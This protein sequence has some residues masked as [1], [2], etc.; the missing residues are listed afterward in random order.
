MNPPLE[1]E[2]TKPQSTTTS[3]SPE[4]RPQGPVVLDEINTKL[5]KIQTSLDSLA[6]TSATTG[7]DVQLL[8]SAV[9]KSLEEFQK[10][11]QQYKLNI[12]DLG[13]MV[14]YIADLQVAPKLGGDMKDRIERLYNAIKKIK[15][16][17]DYTGTRIAGMD[18]VDYVLGDR[19]SIIS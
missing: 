5:G 2:D 6:S 10:T 7:A 1:Q 3:S 9:T 4:S 15:A 18:Y 19:K 17:E 13:A 11:A 14:H 8:N 16:R 12:D